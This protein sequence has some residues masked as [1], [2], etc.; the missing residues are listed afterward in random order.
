M[1]HF[2]TIRIEALQRVILEG[3]YKPGKWLV[4]RHSPR[5]CE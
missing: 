2:G 4:E 1:T 3:A 5:N